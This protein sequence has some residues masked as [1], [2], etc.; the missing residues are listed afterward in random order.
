MTRPRATVAAVFATSMTAVLSVTQIYGVE[1]T[2]A[3]QIVCYTKNTG[4]QFRS[5]MGVGGM[6]F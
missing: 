6:I 2:D 3:G 4:V 1:C 5:G